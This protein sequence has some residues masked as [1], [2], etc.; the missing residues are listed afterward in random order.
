M[1]YMERMWKRSQSQYEVFAFLGHAAALLAQL[2]MQH[3]SLMESTARPLA[4]LTLD[5]AEL[6]FKMNDYFVE[7]VHWV[8][9]SSHRIQ[10]D[11]L[12]AGN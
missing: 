7:Y 3:C 6:Q 11:Y 9:K 5:F 12:G 1:P 4:F 8:Q 10:E 2:N